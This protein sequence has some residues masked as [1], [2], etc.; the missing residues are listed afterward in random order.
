MASI[1]P[2]LPSVAASARA[3]TA[4]RTT[5][6]V[7][8][9]IVLGEKQVWFDTMVKELEAQ[10]AALERAGARPVS[11]DDAWARLERGAAVPRGACVLCFD[12][13]TLGIYEYAFPRLRERG[14]PF[15]VSAHT[16]YVGV[17]TGKAHCTWEQ[18][19]EMEAAGG[20]VRV[21]SQ[22][23]THPPDL[24]A[25]DP[26]A[27]RREMWESKVW[28]EEEMGRAARFVTYPSGKWDRRVALAAA[29]AGY[30]LGFTEDHGH[31]E[32][33]PHLLGVR[34]YST[35]KRFAEAVRAIAAAA[36]PARR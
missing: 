26:K 25:L 4:A 23:H 28:M 27:L 33:S 22:T 10:L 30:R 32:D 31:A 7:W 5:F 36:S 24:R 14:W 2:D 16:K 1:M 17:T 13:N 9:D 3:R 34:R 6:L 18:L 20:S 15:V 12:D 19:R 35:H 8:H 11:L 21:V 29:E